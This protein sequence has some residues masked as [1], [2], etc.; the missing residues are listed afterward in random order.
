MMTA[1]STEQRTES[2]WA[3]LKSPPLRLRKVLNKLI[4]TR[5]DSTPEESQSQWMWRFCLI[6]HMLLFCFGRGGC[7][8][9]LRVIGTRFDLHRAIS[10]IFDGLYLD[11]SSTHDS[12]DCDEDVPSVNEVGESEGITAGVEIDDARGLC[13][14]S[15][16]KGEI[17]TDPALQKLQ[18]LCRCY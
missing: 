14:P 9:A 11:L 3:F 7:C 1:T 17:A 13:P 16:Q 18:E 10:V 2:S 15:E 6:R 8:S 12:E 5:Q 4:S